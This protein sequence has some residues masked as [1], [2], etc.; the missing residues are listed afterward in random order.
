M[1]E[2]NVGDIV[3]IDFHGNLSMTMQDCPALNLEGTIAEIKNVEFD[4]F[5]RKAIYHLK[6]IEVHTKKKEKFEKDQENLFWKD[7]H[8]RLVSKFK[9]LDE[10]DTMS[11]F[12]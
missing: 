12:V 6:F 5:L 2:Y 8:L 1:N 4:S 3:M 9:T 11:L 10:I 7:E